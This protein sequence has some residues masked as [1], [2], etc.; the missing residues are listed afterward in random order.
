[1]LASY[2]ATSAARTPLVLAAWH[3]LAAD[4]DDLEEKRRCLET[5]LGLDPGNESARIALLAVGL[6]EVDE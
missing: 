4:A 2:C 3:W 5:L 6:G 1:L